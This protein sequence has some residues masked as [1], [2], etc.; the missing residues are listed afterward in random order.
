M[1]YITVTKTKPSA[2]VD[3]YEDHKFKSVGGLENVTEGLTYDVTY[4]N[5]LKAFYQENF[6]ENVN[7]FIR[8]SDTQDVIIKFLQD[9][10]DTSLTGPLKEKLDYEANNGITTT[11]S[12]ITFDPSIRL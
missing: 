1:Y 4:D 9:C 3:F 6:N 7:I 10:H 2:N 12:D 8:Q 11:F 5:K